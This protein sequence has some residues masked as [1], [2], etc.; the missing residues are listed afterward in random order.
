MQPLFEGKIDYI[1]KMVGMGKPSTIRLFQDY[2]EV[3]DKSGQ[4]IANVPL[5]SLTQASYVKGGLLRLKAGE[6]SHYLQFFR[7]P[8]RLFGVVGLLLSG[9]SKTGKELADKMAELGVQFQTKLM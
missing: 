6:E 4:Q 2:F 9:S 8:Y 1:Q 7:M 5:R 3:I